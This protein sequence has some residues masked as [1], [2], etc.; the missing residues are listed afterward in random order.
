MNTLVSVQYSAPVGQRVSIVQPVAQSQQQEFPYALRP[1]LSLP[2][3]QQM[4]RIKTMIHRQLLPPNPH[5]ILY[6]SSSE[7]CLHF[8]LC[9]FAECVPVPL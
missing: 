2:Q 6:T 1:F 8:I 4:M 3:Q 7:L 5:P 9:R